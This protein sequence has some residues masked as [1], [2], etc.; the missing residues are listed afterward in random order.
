MENV[1]DGSQPIDMH[2]TVK[3][4]SGVQLCHYDQDA[5]RVPHV[6]MHCWRGEPRVQTLHIVVR[7]FLTASI[8]TDFDVRFPRI[9]A[10]RRRQA[11]GK[12]KQPV[13]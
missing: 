12:Q 2:S 13:S 5:L 7:S 10:Q 9:W 1:A 4:S 8:A 11:L 3:G 6:S